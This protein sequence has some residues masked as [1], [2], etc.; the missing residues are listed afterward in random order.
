MCFL[1]SIVLYTEAVPNCTTTMTS[2]I[3]IEGEYHTMECVM[4]FRASQGV[5]PLMTW[6]GPEPFLKGYSVTNVSVWSG[7]SFTVQR[8]MDALSY[9][10]LTNFTETGFVAPNSASNI[11]TWSNTWRSSQLLV[12]CTYQREN[13]AYGIRCSSA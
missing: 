5:E 1:P 8:N 10:C 7:I 3:V 11:P 12:H 2:P 4:Y 13:G 9:S 6:S